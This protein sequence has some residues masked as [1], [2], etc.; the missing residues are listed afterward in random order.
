MTTIRSTLPPP[1]PAFF[2]TLKTAK[3]A[4]YWLKCARIAVPGQPRFVVTLPHGSQAIFASD[5]IGE[6]RQWIRGQSIEARHP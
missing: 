4:G 2:T 1:P 3:K 6:V 5:D